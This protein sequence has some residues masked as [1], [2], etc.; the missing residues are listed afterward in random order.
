M[1]HLKECLIQ[2][3]NDPQKH[4]KTVNRIQSQSFIFRTI[5][6]GFFIA[7][8]KEVLF[9]PFPSEKELNSNYY[10]WW[11]TATE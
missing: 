1:D 11:K 10:Q 2:V 8:S 7:D 6:N 3:K 5:N 4:T 9:Y